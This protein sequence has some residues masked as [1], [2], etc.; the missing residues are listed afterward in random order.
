[1]KVITLNTNGIRSAERKGFYQWMLKQ[2]AD[3]ICIQETK[4]Q[5]DQL[6]EDI[7]S[8]GKYWGFLTRPGKKVT[9]AL[10]YIHT[11]SLIA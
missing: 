8:P 4:A 10:P 7:L 11:G 6:D 9:A 1:M 3:V 5:V 2:N